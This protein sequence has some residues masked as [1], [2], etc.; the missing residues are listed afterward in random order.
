MGRVGQYS[1]ARGGPQACRG[2]MRSRREE[3]ALGRVLRVACFRPGWVGGGALH[4]EADL[5]DLY[6]RL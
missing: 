4:C 2:S 5:V 3:T 6:D 1:G